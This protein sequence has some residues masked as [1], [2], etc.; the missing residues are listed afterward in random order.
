M[1]KKYVRAGQTS[2]DSVI[3]RMRFACWVTKTD[4]RIYLLLFHGNSGYANTP[5]CYVKRTL[6]VLCYNCLEVG[7]YVH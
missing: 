3:L 6:P 4:Y 1:W 7:G 2:D 5:R